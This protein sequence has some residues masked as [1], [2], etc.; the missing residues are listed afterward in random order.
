MIENTT[1][2]ILHMKAALW[3]LGIPVFVIK[4]IRHKT[5][6]ATVKSAV[7]SGKKFAYPNGSKLK[8]EKVL[9]ILSFGP[10]AKIST[11]L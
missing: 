11:A 10:G 6:T 1:A 2:I 3:S 7:G 5:V 8:Y 4:E 9:V